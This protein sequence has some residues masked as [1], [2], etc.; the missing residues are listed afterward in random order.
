M[1]TFGTDNR[2]GVPVAFNV[3]YDGTVKDWGTNKVLSVSDI[4]NES[5]PIDNKLRISDISISMVD[6]DG[7]IWLELGNGTD[8]FNRDLVVNA[9]IGGSMDTVSEPFGAKVE[10]ISEDGAWNSTIHTG[11]VIDVRKS[12]DIV[13][14]TSQNLMDKLNHLKWQL[15]VKVVLPMLVGSHYRGYSFG[16]PGLTFW[17]D[18]L[19]ESKYNISENQLSADLV[20]YTSDTSDYDMS[21]A[22]TTGKYATQSGTGIR[23]NFDDTNHKFLTSEYYR[24][25]DKDSFK[26]TYIGTFVG[27][28]DDENEAK[29][30]GY[31]DL[32]AAE[33]AKDNGTYAIGRVRYSW[34]GGTADSSINYIIPQMVYK[35]TGDPVAIMEH[36]LFGR[37]VTGIY[38]ESAHK[39]TSSFDTARNVTAFQV[40]TKTIDPNNTSVLE[41][42]RD[43]LSSQSM[44]F[45]VD[46]D[47]KFNIEPYGPKSLLD[48]LLAIGTEEIISS[49]YTNNI[50][51]S[52]NRVELKYGWSF[53]SDRFSK[54][55]D[56]TLTG[57]GSTIDRP[58]LLE[59]KWIQNGNQAKVLVDRLLARYKNT[60][61]KITFKTSLKYAGL[62]IGTLVS[63]SDD[64]S[65]LSSKV[66]QVLDYNKNF[67]S[68]RTITFKGIDGD[69]LFLKRGYGAWEGDD[70]N[71][72]N[73]S[74]TSTGGW[75]TSLGGTEGTCFGINTDKFGTEFV[76]W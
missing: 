64:T 44:L 72:L 38:D 57:W 36:L 25:R 55:S 14:I 33:A 21:W 8:A 17:E 39:N 51:D 50:N 11:K 16:Q 45:Y 3:S 70:D 29:T 67:S 24:N 9:Y 63:L 4:S 54:V 46:T 68:S 43:V 34:D 40:Y 12:G 1:P 75:G 13:T 7:S 5:D 2:W 65:G 22:R 73:V 15:P 62:D 56:G 58:L 37:M 30:F 28:I 23:D 32:A 60:S 61:P 27:T 19:A 66:V 41:D 69:A 18:I 49:S 10:K 53:E 47:N 31:K 48:S 76:W 74:G 52:Y 35:I 20:G 26:A 59:S 6:R 42:I 71:D